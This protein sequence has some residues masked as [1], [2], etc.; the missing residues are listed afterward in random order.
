LRKIHLLVGVPLLAGALLVGGL[1][2]IAEPPQTSG[3]Q[4]VANPAIPARYAEQ[5]INWKPCFP[6][7]P[8]QGLP[9]GAESL[10]CGSFSSPRDWL[11][12]DDKID[13]TVAVSRLRTT[14][15][16]KG[17]V[18]TNPG[19][20]GAPGRT[21]PL[22]FL[23]RQ[24]L[25]DSQEI[26]G[27]DPRGSGESSNIT[28]GGQSSLGSDLDA[29][30]RSQAN[31]D[32]I[33]NSN[34]L[35]A[36]NCQTRSGEL[37]AYI[38]TEQTVRDIDLLRVLLGRE[39]INWVGYSG[40]TWLGAHY[41]TAF[42][43]RV[44]AFVLDSNVEFT[45]SFEESF[46]WQPLG[47]ERRWR[48]DFLNWA[49]RYDALYHLGT[50]GEAARQTYETIRASL[51]R[52]PVLVDGQELTANLFDYSIVPS[53]Y[54][55]E[56]FA[57]LADF[58]VS[59]RTLTE[60]PAE[61]APARAAAARVT[62]FRAKLAGQDPMPMAPVN[63]EDAYPASFISITCNDTPWDGDERSLVKLSDKLGKKYPLIGW[64]WVAQPCIFWNRPNVNLP[65]PT[66]AGVPPVLMVQST[67][68]PATP[69][70]GAQRAHQAFAGS[71]MVTVT[72][73]GDHGIYAL[74][75]NACVDD[76]VESYIVDG[77]VPGADQSCAGMPLPNPA[78]AAVATTSGLN[79][80]LEYRKIAGPLPR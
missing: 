76:L 2:A 20:P 21:L 77:V 28:C 29:R 26:V 12:P 27:M 69:L 54:S 38:N 30:D 37:G 17:S 51:T 33:L 53:L 41:A 71:R 60:Q 16:P 70:E 73:E 80:V 49:A 48:E 68:D 46:N 19:G 47:F 1:S 57:G 23:G 14:P 25:L 63:Y 34:K 6:D 8:P 42:P 9:P 18:V 15:E 45:T 40:G 11:R 24:K 10:E 7:G 61:A 67:N 55:K 59:V 3:G 74:T 78:A 22:A 75:G 4:A 58:L 65:A 32:L 35:I 79:K 36:Q 43:D 39:K 52:K 44:G 50:T 72:G 5:Q 31:L 62:E 56:D 13:I 66:G 64:S